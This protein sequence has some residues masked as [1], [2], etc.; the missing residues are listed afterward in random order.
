M[1]AIFLHDH[2]AVVPVEQVVRWTM[3]NIDPRHVL[4]ALALAL[5]WIALHYMENG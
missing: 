5:A 1:R 2:V 3:L 4:F